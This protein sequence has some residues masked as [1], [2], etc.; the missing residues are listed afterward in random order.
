M[1]NGIK[2]WKS[3]IWL[4][5]RYKRGNSLV[6]KR[7]HLVISFPCLFATQE[8]TKAFSSPAARCPLGNISTW[9]RFEHSQFAPSYI[10]LAHLLVRENVATNIDALEVLGCPI[11]EVISST[12]TLSGNYC[13]QTERNKIHFHQLKYRNGVYKHKASALWKKRGGKKLRKKHHGFK[14]IK[15]L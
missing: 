11:S 8:R 7:N 4:S 13:T 3:K 6:W 2:F 10:M 9:G 12:G 14:M 15:A 5:N 1:K